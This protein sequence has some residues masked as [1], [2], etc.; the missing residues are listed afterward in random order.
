MKRSEKKSSELGFFKKFAIEIKYHKR[1][2]KYLRFKDKIS[3]FIN[4]IIMRDCY[5]GHKCFGDGE[6]RRLD[7]RH[8]DE[9]S[10]YEFIC[11]GCYSTASENLNK[12]WKEIEKIESNPLSQVGERIDGNDGINRVVQIPEKQEEANEVFTRKEKKKQVKGG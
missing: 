9:A 6:M 8:K 7:L 12:K 1:T 2:L 10:N 4:Q 11:E 3:Y 5:S